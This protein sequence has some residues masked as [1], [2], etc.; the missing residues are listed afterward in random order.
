MG[1]KANALILAATVST[2]ASLT[3]AEPLYTVNSPKLVAN[4][5]FEQTLSESSVVTVKPLQAESDVANADVTS[6]CLW[7]VTVML[8]GGIASFK[9]GKMI[10]IGPQQEVLETI[11]Q[12]EVVPFG[13]CVDGTCEQY[14]VSANELVEMTLSEPLSFSLQPRN[15]RQ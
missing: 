4:A 14:K 8:E 9:P 7:S 13:Q 5:L 1:F 11:P 2:V 6:Q 3:F 15:E 10:C 12:G